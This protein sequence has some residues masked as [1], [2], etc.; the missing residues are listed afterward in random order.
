[1]K[2]NT[3]DLVNE[4]ATTKNISQ[5]MDSNQEEFIDIPLHVQLKK[6]LADTGVS[7][8]RIVE[9]SCRGDYVYQVFR[10]SKHLAEMCFYVSPW[11]WSCLPKKQTI[12]CASPICPC[13]I[14]ETGEI[15]SSSL[16]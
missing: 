2:K 3:Q 16:P 11:Q 14:S 1:M 6:L 7:V 13:W 8:S 10:E 9:K 5:Y 15:P 12:Y 4:I